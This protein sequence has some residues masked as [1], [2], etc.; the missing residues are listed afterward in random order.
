MKWAAI[1]FRRKDVEGTWPTSEQLSWDISERPLCEFRLEVK[2][3]SSP[4]YY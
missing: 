1:G 4:L 2:A 3:M